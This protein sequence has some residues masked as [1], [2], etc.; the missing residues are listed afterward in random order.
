MFLRRYVTVTFGYKFLD[1]CLLFDLLMYIWTKEDEKNS[2]N[3]SNKLFSLF[4]TKK[5]DED[6]FKSIDFN[7][8]MV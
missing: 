2:F 3:N 8:L 7:I 4:L 1:Y 5:F 6:Q